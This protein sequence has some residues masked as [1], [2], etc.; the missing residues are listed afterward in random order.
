MDNHYHL[1]LETPSGNLPQIMRHI[2]G[3]YTTY[4]NIKRDRSGHLFQGRYKAILVEKDAYAKELSRYIHLNPVRAGIVS[5]PVA[6]EWT[7][8]PAYAGAKPSPEWLVRGFILGCFSPQKKV[9]QKRYKAFVESNP[10]RPGDSPLTNLPGGMILGSEQFVETICAEHLSDKLPGRDLPALKELQIKPQASQVEAMVDRIVE[11]DVKL[12]RDL[13]IYFIRKH[14]G[15]PLKAIG[16]RF[17]LGESGVSQV[18]R[19]LDRRKVKDAA[20]QQVMA[21]IDM[22]MKMSRV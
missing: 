7:S 15:T 2:N 12:A 9:A 21:K 18:S 8:Y 16:E 4:F 19:R 22:A 17:G 3:A 5:K 1:L 14:S 11:D 6:Y 20:L 13:K 10:G